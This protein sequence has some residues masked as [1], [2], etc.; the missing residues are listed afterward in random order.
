MRVHAALTIAA[1][2]AAGLLAGCGDETSTPTSS[3]EATPPTTAATKPAPPPIVELEVT[4]PDD[5]DVIKR[6]RVVVR[7]TAESGADVKVDGH[8]V[9]V[10]EDGAWARTVR[11]DLG[12]QSIPVEATKGGREDD[13]TSVTVTR[14]RSAAELRAI[15][16]AQE[17]RERQR[18][19]DFRAAATTIP[20]AQLEKNAKPYKGD[21]VV[22]RGQIFQIQEDDFGGWM[23]LSVTDDG[24]GFWDDNIWVDYT[25]HIRGAEGDIV[26]VY[27]TITGTKSYETQ[28]GGETYVPKM[29]AEY[30]DE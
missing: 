17:E 16:E 12:R 27:G 15:R 24:Y 8:R 30:I 11:L 13:A 5:G 20:Y 21:R 6:D 14:R 23:L 25:D 28:I 9:R 1:A 7:G 19:A 26:T 10:H 3:T 2:V 4:S 29:R 18:E 22:Y